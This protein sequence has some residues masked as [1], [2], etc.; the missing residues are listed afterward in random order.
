MRADLPGSET[1][2]TKFGSFRREVAREDDSVTVTSS[3]VL[4]T[5]R[6]SVDDYPGFR[7]FAISVDKLISERMKVQW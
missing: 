6:V 5:A 3:V 4:S 2:E 1:L 7:D